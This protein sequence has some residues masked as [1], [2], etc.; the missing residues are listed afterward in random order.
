MA[1]KKT[2]ITE[3]NKVECAEPATEPTPKK[4]VIDISNLNLDEKVTVRNLANWDVGFTRKHD[5]TGD[6]TIV[7]G[8]QQRLSRNE[9]QAQVN[10]QNK[11]FSGTDG[12]GSHASVYIE[13]EATRYLLGFEDESHKQLVFSD[14]LVKELFDMKFENYKS[15][16]PEYISTRAEK[17]AFKEAINRLGLNDYRKIM[18]A[19]EY[20]GYKI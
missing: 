8:G 5:G 17:Y 11:L 12:V 13:D 7:A 15:A 16:L 14:E 9:I 2:V 18:F 19:S 10:N 3:N 6:I 20:T 4:K 1:N